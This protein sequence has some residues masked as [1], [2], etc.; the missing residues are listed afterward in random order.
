MLE[1]DSKMILKLSF[2]QEFFSRFSSSSK[3][4]KRKKFKDASLRLISSV[5]KVL[6]LFLVRKKD[7]VAEFQVRQYSRLLE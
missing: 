4:T 2:K 5:L 6:F 7:F 3:M 1:T